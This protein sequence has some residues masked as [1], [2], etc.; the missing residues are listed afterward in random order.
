MTISTS[1]GALPKEDAQAVGLSEHDKA[2]IAKAD[3]AAGITPPQPATRPEHIPEKFWDA[4]TGQVKVDDLAKSYA[5]L[6]RGRSQAPASDATKT[7]EEA[8]KAAGADTS[9][10][11]F[12]ALSQ[13]FQ[14][15]GQLS[16][17]TYQKLEQSGL[18]RNLV[19]QFIAGQMALAAQM[20]QEAF[21]LVGGQD[22]YTA[23]LDWAAQNLSKAEQD[24]FDAAVTGNAAQRKQAIVALQAQFERAVGK[25]PQLVSGNA[26]SSVGVY[27]SRAEMVR[28]MQN[29]KYQTDPAF[30]AMVQQKLAASDIF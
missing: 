23:M 19:D 26:G 9:Q 11:D 13:E 1:Q 3:A 2:M 7:A 22:Q 27:Q 14:A 29:P 15:N 20:E 17:E 5:E 24:A 18:D 30:R 12:N 16:P 21:S 28:D 10:L 25:N 8:A 4:A 6:E